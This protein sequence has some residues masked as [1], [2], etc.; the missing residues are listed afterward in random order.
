PDARPI[1]QCLAQ[2]LVV[3]FEGGGGVDVDGR[4]YVLGDAAQRDA[5]AGELAPRQLEVIHRR[6][7]LYGSGRTPCGGA[8]PGSCGPPSIGRVRGGAGSDVR[9]RGSTVSTGRDGSR[10]RSASSAS[11]VV[12]RPAPNSGPG[13]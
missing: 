5:L 8:R 7:L 10:A 2:H 12:A 11:A 1:Y 9:S 6:G 3:P 4:A 13:R